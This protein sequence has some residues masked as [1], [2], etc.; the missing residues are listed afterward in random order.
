MGPMRAKETETEGGGRHILGD[1]MVH[2]NEEF[3][4]RKRRISRHPHVHV[5][6]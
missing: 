4:Y 6:Q 5:R 1:Q 2:L 3:P